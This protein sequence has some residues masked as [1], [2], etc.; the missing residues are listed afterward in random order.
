M[1]CQRTT[2][3]IAHAMRHHNYRL[4][5]Y[6]D[7]LLGCQKLLVTATAADSY[8]GETLDSLGLAHK[9]SKHCPPAQQQICLGILFDTVKMSKAIPDT[10][11]AEINT[12]L[13]KWARKSTATRH[14]LQS[15]A[16]R[17][18]FIA[19]CSKPARLFINSLL[20]DLRNAPDTGYTQL[21]PATL[22]DIH[23]FRE[24]MPLYNGISLLHHPPLDPHHQVDLDACLSGFGAKSGQEF[25]MEQLP[26]FLLQLN[27]SITHLEMLNILVAT[28]LFSTKWSHHTINLGC[29]NQAAVAVLQS[30][31]ARDRLLA[32]C[33]KQIWLFAAAYDFTL[34]PFHRPGSEMQQL[35]IDALSRHH[36][37]PKFRAI[38]DNMATTGHR[39]RVPVS[40]FN[41]PPF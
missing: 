34:M 10:K 9:R 30:A 26:D 6:L 21:S 20:A 18:L 13:Q 19:K 12:E 15:L 38:V 27:L 16:G 11:L 5:V 24:L 17:L 25:Y 8:L 41:L 32:A 1:M 7:D 22:S 14:E 28:R 29:D 39:V 36:L 2:E 31:K 3:V 37:S 33:A 40:L 35:G 4:E 23:W